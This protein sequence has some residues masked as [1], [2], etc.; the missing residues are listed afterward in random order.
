LVSLLKASGHI[1]TDTDQG[2]GINEA[3]KES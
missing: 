3:K 2:G 1:V